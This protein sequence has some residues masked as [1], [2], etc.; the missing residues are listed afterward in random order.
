MKLGSIAKEGSEFYDDKLIVASYHKIAIFSTKRQLK[1]LKNSLEWVADGTFK[2]SPQSTYQIYRIFG[3]V[4][5]YVHIKV[6]N[7]NNKLILIEK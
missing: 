1:L 3:F 7:N 6:N 4:S 2:F 5:G